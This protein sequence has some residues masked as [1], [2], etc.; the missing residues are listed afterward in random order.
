MF[1]KRQLCLHDVIKKANPGCASLEVCESVYG[2]FVA[3]VTAP[4]GDLDTSSASQFTLSKIHSVI[5]SMQQLYILDDLI[6]AID[7]DLCARPMWFIIVK[8]NI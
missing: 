5:Q 3:T 6:C 7:S 2:S 4:M 8:K 1:P